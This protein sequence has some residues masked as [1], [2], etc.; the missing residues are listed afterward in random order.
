MI[1]IQ[2]HN[3]HKQYMYIDDIFW[4]MQQYKKKDHNDTNKILV[5]LVFIMF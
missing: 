2:K 5:D 3:S 1:H 4:T